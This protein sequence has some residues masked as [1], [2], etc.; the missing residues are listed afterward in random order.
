MAVP[1][2]ACRV[3]VSPHVYPPSIT[4]AQS[5]YTGTALYTRLSYSHGYLNQ[6]RL[7][8]FVISVGCQRL[9]S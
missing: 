3:V 2:T 9:R 4:R 1:C 5:A 8:G 6:V 7:P